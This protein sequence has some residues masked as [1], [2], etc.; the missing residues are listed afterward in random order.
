MTTTMTASQTAEPPASTTAAAPAR[1]FHAEIGYAFAA[2]GAVLFS[3]KGIAIK[4]AYQEPIDAT[5]L[6]TLRMLLALPIY[7]AIAVQAVGDHRRRAVALPPAGLALKAALIGAL[8]YWL[9]S[10]LDFA[11][12]EYL[13]AQFERLILYTYPLFVVIFGALFFG[14]GL[15]PKAMAAIALSYVGL[16]AIFLEKVE[17]PG[18]AVWVGASLVFGSAIAFALYQLFAKTVIAELGPRLFTCIAMTGAAF[19]VFAQFLLT[20]PIGIVANVSPRLWEIALFLAIGATV[21][22]SFFLNAALHRISAQAN[23]TI[24]TLSPVVTVV[25]AVAILGEHLTFPDVVG[26]ALVLVGVGWFS[27]S[28]RRG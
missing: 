20:R 3:T 2:A 15:R 27:L 25:L 14:A 16:A 18:S 24:A 13:S 12:L 10:Y 5:L 11:G 8:G 1:R 22:P 4:L 17:Q 28:E 19:A 7:W 23:S 9:A 6:L 21:L 26:T